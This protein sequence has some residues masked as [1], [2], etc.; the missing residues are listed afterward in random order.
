MSIV[1]VELTTL[2][3]DAKVFGRKFSNFERQLANLN[4]RFRDVRNNERQLVSR[5]KREGFYAAKVMRYS[6][7]RWHLRCPIKDL[8]L[9]YR[10]QEGTQLMFIKRRAR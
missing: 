7:K 6:G 2:R 8:G 3:R 10:K 1:S 4:K 9:R 5:N